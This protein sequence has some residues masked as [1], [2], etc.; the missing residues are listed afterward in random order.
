MAQD[1]YDLL[2]QSDQLN[3]ERAIGN[4][5]E[6][7]KEGE[8][9]FAPTFKRKAYD[10][11]SFGMKRN[12]A[13]TDRILYFCNNDEAKEENECRLQ[14]KSYDSNNLIDNSDHRPVFAQFL[15]DLDLTNQG[16]E[17]EREDDVDNNSQV[18]GVSS[19]SRLSR[20]KTK[21]LT[22]SQLRAV[23]DEKKTTGDIGATKT[24]ACTIF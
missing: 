12:P 20:H 11:S 10:N 18:S 4:I 5:P 15:F 6:I 8:I 21:L 3:F 24:K 19:K 7:F 17:S 2:I 1:R 14:L 23:V 16:S 22:E 9:A 13:Y